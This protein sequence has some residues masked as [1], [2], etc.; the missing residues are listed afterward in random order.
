MVFIEVQVKFIDDVVEGYLIDY[1]SDG[2]YDAFHNNLTRNDTD[3]ELQD[4][5]K[6]LMDINGSGTWDYTYDSK[7]GTINFI[8]DKKTIEEIEISWVVVVG[9]ILVIAIIVIVILF[10]RGYLSIEEIPPDEIKKKTG[11]KK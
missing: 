11:R 8:K 10:K 1:E 2:I 4:N 7:T 3:V 9:I 6:Y 5:G